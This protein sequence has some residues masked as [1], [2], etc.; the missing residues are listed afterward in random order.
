MQAAR[1]QPSVQQQ[2]P[3]VSASSLPIMTQV[4]VPQTTSLVQPTTTTTPAVDIARPRAK[5]RLVSERDTSSDD[6]DTEQPAP[7]QR[8]IYK[9]D[10][11]FATL[12]LDREQVAQYEACK[13]ACDSLEQRQ[14]QL[15]DEVEKAK[16]RLKTVE[17][18]LQMRRDMHQEKYNILITQVMAKLNESVSK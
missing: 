5:A 16:Q 1:R 8:K 17:Q 6:E 10:A 11:I 2:P 3:V 14:K 18:K 13:Q 15:Q 7:K 12:P 9:Y 4:I